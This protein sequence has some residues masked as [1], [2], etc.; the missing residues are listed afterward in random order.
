V[1]A[2]FMAEGA[3]GIGR[4]V[5][6]LIPALLSSE[7]SMS[8]SV[9]TSSKAPA[10]F[11][12]A[13][14]A[15]E[16]EWSVLPKGPDSHWNVHETLLA[17]PVLAR[18]RRLDVLHSP[19]NVGPV[20][21]PG[22]ANVLTLHDLIWLREPE[23]VGMSA[24]ARTSTRLLARAAARAADRV[25]TGAEVAAADL[26]ATFGVPRA[27]IDVVPH[28]ARAPHVAPAPED[29]VRKRLGLGSRRVVLSVGQRRPYKNLESLVRA[30]AAVDDQDVALVLA[31]APGPSDA[32]I[33]AL[34]AELGVADRVIL[35]SWL[36]EEDLEALYALA[37]CV[38]QPSLIE[39]F[40]L[41]VLEAMV[42]GA[43]VGCSDRSTLGEI[44]GDAALTF[45]PGDQAAITQAM[46][47]LLGD[48]ALRDDLARRGAARASGYTWER[49]ARATAEVYRRAA[50]RGARGVAA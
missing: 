8:L 5:T 45:D 35:C 32:P 36:E 25:I 41:P 24:R 40:G 20:V 31:G 49:T 4:Y 17:L 11:R 6:E 44:A 26:T 10:D 46:R 21:L 34:G 12:E 7:P 33:E 16:V 27:K 38:M 48:A 29:G 37:T 50:A 42:R 23:L 47:R 14:W 2:I 1:N 39:G 13:A 28:A 15:G 30:L 9:F 19:A 3:G 22:V 43:P 18:R